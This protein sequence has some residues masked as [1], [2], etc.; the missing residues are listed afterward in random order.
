MTARLGRISPNEPM[1]YKDWVIP[2]GVNIYS[3]PIAIATAIS[4]DVCNTNSLQ[5]PISQ[6][7][8]FVHMDSTLFPEPEK[9]DPERWVRAA[10]NGEYLSRFI[11]AFTKGS[12]QCLGMK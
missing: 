6:S 3:F 1:L 7:N 9:F 11:V 2:A 5:T 10:E 4:F 12:R 8:Y